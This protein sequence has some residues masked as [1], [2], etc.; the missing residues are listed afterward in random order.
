VG[1]EQVFDLQLQNQMKR[2]R[3]KRRRRRR[4]KK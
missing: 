2:R 1:V 3:K 4:M